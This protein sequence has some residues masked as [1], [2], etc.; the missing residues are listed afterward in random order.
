MNTESLNRGNASLRRGSRP[1]V[2]ATTILIG[3]AGLVAVLSRGFQTFQLAAIAQRPPL[4]W[5]V[6][7]LIV[8]AIMWAVREARQEAGTQ[9]TETGIERDN[10]TILVRWDDVAAAHYV[11]GWLQLEERGGRKVTVNLLFASSAHDVIEAVQG[12]LPSGARLHVY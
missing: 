5:L 11:R 6:S 9:L 8:A 10:G 12:C 3:A 4:A 1:L 7:A 2:L